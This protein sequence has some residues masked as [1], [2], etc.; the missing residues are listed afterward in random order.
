MVSKAAEYLAEIHWCSMSK[1]VG[2][3]KTQFGSCR[4]VSVNVLVLA[5]SSKSW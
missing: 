2:E 5:V 1:P 4:G 3:G